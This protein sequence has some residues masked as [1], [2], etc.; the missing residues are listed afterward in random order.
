MTRSV[1]AKRRL[2][3]EL[4]AASPYLALFTIIWAAGEILGYLA[5]PGEALAEIE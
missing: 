5:G 1:L 3:S 2:R 4:A